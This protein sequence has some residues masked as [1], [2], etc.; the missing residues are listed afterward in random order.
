MAVTLD[1]VLKLITMKNTILNSVIYESLLDLIDVVKYDLL[2]MPF[3]F[4]DYPELKSQFKFYVEKD[5]VYAISEK[6]GLIFSASTIE[7]LP[8]AFIDAWM[9]YYDIPRY[10]AKKINENVAIRFDSGEMIVSQNKDHLNYA[11]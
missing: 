9:T 6:K 3:E 10:Q 8:D 1:F 5:G 4:V 7:G 2:K 11:G